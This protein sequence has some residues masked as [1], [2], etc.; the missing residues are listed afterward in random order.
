[1]ETVSDPTATKGKI[2]RDSNGDCWE[3]VRSGSRVDAKSVLVDAR[4]VLPESLPQ[5]E[6]V[7]AHYAEQR[8][9]DAAPELLAALQ[10]IVA[11]DEAIEHASDLLPGDRSRARFAAL[12]AAR[13]AIIKAT[14]G[15]K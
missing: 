5:S 7:K 6:S 14:G 11:A 9:R 4:S 3:W 1:M 2:K 13:A 12:D 10:A 8:V 15:I